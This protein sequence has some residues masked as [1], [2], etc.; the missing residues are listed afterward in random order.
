M[1]VTSVPRISAR[2]W[3]SFAQSSPS[4]GTSTSLFLTK[5]K[6]AR[7]NQPQEMLVA[8]SMPVVNA[9]IALTVQKARGSGARI[10]LLSRASLS[11]R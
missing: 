11:R 10:A 4:S 1:M 5:N 3:V 9:L 2:R 6:H 8:P 7:I